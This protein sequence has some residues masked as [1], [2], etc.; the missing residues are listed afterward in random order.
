MQRPYSA[1]A[2]QVVDCVQEPERL[3]E[4][5]VWSPGLDRY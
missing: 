3:G 4:W 2:E 1:F 5:K